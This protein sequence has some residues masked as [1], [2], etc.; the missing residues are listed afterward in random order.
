MNAQRQ[1]T[2]TENRKSLWLEC[3]SRAY[4]AARSYAG[5]VLKVWSYGA[6]RS[7]GLGEQEA[8]DTLNRD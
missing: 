6:A 8:K 4:T 5:K 2:A 3:A 7:T 1:D